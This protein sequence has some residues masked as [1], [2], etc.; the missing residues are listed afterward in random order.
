MFVSVLDVFV[1]KDAPERAKSDDMQCP[2]LLP[3]RLI[4]SIAGDLSPD[5]GSLFAADLSKFL[6]VV[7]HMCTVSDHHCGDPLLVDIRRLVLVGSEQI[8]HMLYPGKTP[9]PQVELVVHSKYRTDGTQ[10]LNNMQTGISA[11]SFCLGSIVYATKH[12]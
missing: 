7:R 8:K 4:R 10:L 12:N 2:S 3:S 11:S 5:P 9:R 1:S 6:L